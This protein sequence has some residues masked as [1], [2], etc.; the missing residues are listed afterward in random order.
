MMQKTIL[1]LALLSCMGAAVAGKPAKSVH[2]VTDRE[3]A[4]V[5]PIPVSIKGQSQRDVTCL[6]YSIFREAGNQPQPAQYAVG[7]IHINRLKSGKWGTTMCQV[8]YA[9]AQFSWTLFKIKDKDVWSAAQKGY[10]ME[11]ADQLINDGVRV[12][13][14]NNVEIQH[15]H[16]TYVKPKW[17]K[18]GIMVAKAGSHVFYKGVD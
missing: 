9:H 12:K 14:L 1:S 15:Y 7:Q 18:D 5:S 4:Q 6:A 10:Y 3:V 16:A 17:R 11:M 8:V 13:S 2:K